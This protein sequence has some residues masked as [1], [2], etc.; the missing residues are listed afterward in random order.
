MSGD[1]EHFILSKY[2]QLKCVLGDFKQPTGYF[3]QKQFQLEYV[4]G[5][6]K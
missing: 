2:F 3:F 4:A 6:Y 5:Y 1:L